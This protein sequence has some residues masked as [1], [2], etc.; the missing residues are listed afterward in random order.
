MFSITPRRVKSIPPSH[1][2]TVPCPPGESAYLI[3]EG[4]V[5]H[6]LLAERVP[7]AC[8]TPLTNVGDMHTYWL[9]VQGCTVA[10]FIAIVSAFAKQNFEL[11]ERLIDEI[12]V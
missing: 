3:T 12:E 8:L 11:A 9:S 10:H 2:G 6:D 4:I 7:G 1:D 5:L